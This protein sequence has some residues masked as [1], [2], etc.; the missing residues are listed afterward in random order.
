LGEGRHALGGCLVFFDIVFSEFDA[1]GTEKRFGFMTVGA[2]AGDKYFDTG[3][4][5]GISIAVIFQL[6]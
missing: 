5:L 6:I 1:F 3:S 4:R 2:P